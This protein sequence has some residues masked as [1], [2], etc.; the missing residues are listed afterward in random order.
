MAQLSSI[1]GISDRHF[2][3]EFFKTVQVSPKEYA[4]IIQFHRALRL[5]SIRGLSIADAAFEAGYADQPHMT[6]AFKRFGGFS[7]NQIP[8]QLSL[9]GLPI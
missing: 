7:P 2:R 6:R 1:G 8:K 4:S 3:R 9:P 5:V